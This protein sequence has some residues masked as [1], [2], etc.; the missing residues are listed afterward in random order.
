MIEMNA[1]E[2]MDADPSDPV[3][4]FVSK[5]MRKNDPRADSIRNQ[6]YVVHELPMYAKIAPVEFHKQ[7]LGKQAYTWNGSCRY[8]VWEG[9]GWRAYVN[10]HKGT[11]VELMYENRTDDQRYA[12]W[13]DYTSRIGVSPT[14]RSTFYAT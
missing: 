5:L 1:R 12:A 4:N 13:L 8:W 10:N 9:P 14:A 6:M 2:K 11:C 3:L 7:R